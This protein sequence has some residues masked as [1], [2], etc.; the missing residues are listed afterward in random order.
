MSRTSVL[1]ENKRLIRII[2]LNGLVVTC[3]SAAAAMRIECTR[4]AERK[5]KSRFK[6]PASTQ[7]LQIDTGVTRP[8][9]N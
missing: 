4:D 7:H 5:I 2:E 3:P 1:S 9:G 6:E 8:G